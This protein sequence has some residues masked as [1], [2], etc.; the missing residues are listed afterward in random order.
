MTADRERHVYLV[1]DR[2]R[3]DSIPGLNILSSGQAALDVARGQSSLVCIVDHDLPDMP[4]ASL[5]NQLQKIAPRSA[6]AIIAE[7][8]QMDSALEA[9]ATHEADRIIPAGTDEATVLRHIEALREHQ[10]RLEHLTEAIRDYPAR[11]LFVTG[12]TGFL[13]QQFIRDV[14]RC[15]ELKVTALSRSRKGVPFDQRLPFDCTASADRLSFVEGDVQ[16]ENLGLSEDQRH[17]LAVS[18]DEVWHLA[19]VTS[20][21]EIL[22]EKTFAVNLD[23]TKRVLEF[24]KTVTGLQSFNHV[25]TAYVSGDRGYPETVD[26]QLNARPDRFRNPYDE[27]KFEAEQQ[28]ADS[29]LPYQIFRPSI[30]LGETVSGRCDGQTVYN[31]AKMVRLAKTLGEQDCDAKGLP[32][33]HHSFRV[34][35][36]LDAAK[37]MIP[38]DTVNHLMLNIRASRPD[39]GSIFHLTHPEPTSIATFVEVIAELLEADHYEIVSSLEGE[40]LSIPEMTLERVASVFRPY[41]TASDPVYRSKN[42]EGIL[43]AIDYPRLTTEFLRENMNQFYSQYFGA[44]YACPAATTA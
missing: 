26:E 14:L 43:G 34:V 17:A 5:L 30:V 31:I 8:A 11:H 13:G 1:S 44:D 12:A 36:N 4:G 9:I 2:P 37:N 42:V 20:F 23:G 10:R 41:M 16:L 28:V 22:R 27:S 6:C 29:G 21:D 15:S 19:A 24:A 39:T 3:W 7:S 25:S 18:V 32:H 38:V 35:A 40:T 33:D